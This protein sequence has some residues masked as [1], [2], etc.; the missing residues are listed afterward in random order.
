MVLSLSILQDELFDVHLVTGITDCCHLFWERLK[1]M[2]L[3]DGI[4]RS[5]RRDVLRLPGMNH[6]VFMLYFLNNFRRRGV[7]TSPAYIPY[8][9]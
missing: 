7:P 6:V 4:S 1:T 2:T 5:R 3:E 8:S 9:I